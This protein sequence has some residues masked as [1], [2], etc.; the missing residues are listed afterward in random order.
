MKR[1]VRLLAALGV[2]VAAVGA[3]AVSG[4]A[5][6]GANEIK[7]QNVI[8]ERLSGFQEDPLAFSTPG[9][10]TF[11]ARINDSDQSISYR[12]SWSGLPTNVVQAHIHLGQ[13]AQ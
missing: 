7:V 10:A 6:A 13:R 11:I 12:L 3:G 2:V 8:F 4:I 5:T 9:T 1:S